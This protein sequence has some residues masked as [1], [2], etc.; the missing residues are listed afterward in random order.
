[1]KDLNALKE[2]EVPRATAKRL[3]IY[4]RYYVSCMMQENV[5]SHQLN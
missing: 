3:A 2:I 1:M 4:H 5:A